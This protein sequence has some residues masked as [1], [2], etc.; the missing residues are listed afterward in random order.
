MNKCFY[1]TQEHWREIVILNRIIVNKHALPAWP[2][3]M[4]TAANSLCVRL[5]SETPLTASTSNV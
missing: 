5:K 2:V 4:L 3:A 1:P